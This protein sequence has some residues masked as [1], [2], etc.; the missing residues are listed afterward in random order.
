MIP[1]TSDFKHR[2]HVNYGVYDLHH[3]FSQAKGLAIEHI[4]V[5]WLSADAGDK[6]LSSFE[7]ARARNRWL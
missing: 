5:S 1:V 3:R 2:G 6:I 4:F 7:Y